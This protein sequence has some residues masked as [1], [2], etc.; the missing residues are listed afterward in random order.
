MLLAINVQLYLENQG[1]LKGV[2]DKDPN[3]V[4]VQELE[5]ILARERHGRQGLI[6]VRVHRMDGD[7]AVTIQLP[8]N[9]VTLSALRARLQDSYP[10]T[11]KINWR[12]IWSSYCLVFNDRYL[13][14]NNMNFDLKKLGLKDHS[15][16]TFK[17][18]IRRRRKDGPIRLRDNE[19]DKYVLV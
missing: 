17:K 16:L 9:K 11:E 5:N 6:S 14:V 4:S 1:I 7:S 12:Y 15:E 2:I 8:Q 18:L 13:L 10:K 19:R 3:E